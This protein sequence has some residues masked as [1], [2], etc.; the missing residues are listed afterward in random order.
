MGVASG[1]TKAMKLRALDVEI[2]QMG[3]LAEAQLN[4]AISAFERRD[5]ALAEK[6]VHDDLRIDAAHHHVEQDAI[7]ILGS[8]RI[9]GVALREVLGAIKMAS[10]LE[11]IGD[12][13]KNVAKR[14]RVITRAAP[15]D[16]VFKGTSRMGRQSLLLVSDVLD[17]YAERNLNGARAV[18]GADDNIDELYNSL[19]Q[20]TLSAMITDST[21]VNACTQLVFVAKNFERIGDHAT[22]I[23][24]ILHFLVTGDLLDAP[25]PKGDETAVTSVALQ[26]S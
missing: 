13:A 19:F 20:D 25:R 16:A 10:E 17:A 1:D 26:D 7:A 8:E 15:D 9:E 11:R 4:D 6:V 24:E 21:Q 14:T 23:A 22:N 12:L 2:S 18:W 5:L 3:A